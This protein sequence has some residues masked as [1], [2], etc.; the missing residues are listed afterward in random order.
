[1][2]TN[3][4]NQFIVDINPFNSVAMRTMLM[5]ENLHEAVNEYITKFVKDVHFNILDMPFILMA[6]DVIHKS[7]ETRLDDKDRELY[8]KLKE[9]SDVIT[10]HVDK[11]HNRPEEPKEEDDV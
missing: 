4:Q 7:L 8:Q 9:H 1:M 5:G 10:M 6:L 3:T 2:D 11:T